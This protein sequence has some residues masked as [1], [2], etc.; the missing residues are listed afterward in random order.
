M[1]RPVDLKESPQIERSFLS[2]LL[3]H[4]H[5]YVLFEQI[6]SC[7]IITVS[8]ASKKYWAPFPSERL[9]GVAF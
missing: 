4:F 1:S 5:T 7:L 2:K 9:L 6:I 3:D 8:L